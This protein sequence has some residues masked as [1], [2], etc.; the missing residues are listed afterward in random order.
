ML[1]ALQVD[2][3]SGESEFDKLKPR[4]CA[5]HKELDRKQETGQEYFRNLDTCIFG[6]IPIEMVPFGY[7]VFSYTVDV[8]VKEMLSGQGQA[9]K[10]IPAHVEDAKD[11]FQEMWGHKTVTIFWNL[12]SL[13]LVDRGLANSLQEKKCSKRSLACVFFVEF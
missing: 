5:V 3:N 12:H 9:K 7:F 8:E 6:R 13:K 4:M 11:V 1:A 2:K 10:F